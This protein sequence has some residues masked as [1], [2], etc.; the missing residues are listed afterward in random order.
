MRNILS[1]EETERIRVAIR[2]FAKVI[3]EFCQQEFEANRNISRLTSLY[4]INNNISLCFNIEPVLEMVLNESVKLFEAERAFIMLLNEDKTEMKIISSHGLEREI[5]E[6]NIKVGEGI[7]GKVALSGKSRLIR[8]K[9]NKSDNT[10][11]KSLM[12]VPLKAR[13]KVL[14]VVNISGNRK[15]KNFTEDDMNLL[16]T[17]ASNTAI[18]IENA[19]LY[20]KLEKKA[21]ELSTLFH[22]GNAINSSLD[23]DQVLQKVLDSAI[24]L[25][26]S[27]KGS[28]ML[29]GTQTDEMRIVAAHG[30]PPEIISNARVKLGEGISGKVALEGKPRLMKKGVRIEESKS[31]KELKEIKSAMSAPLTFKN[32]TQGVVNISDK[33]TDDNFNEEDMALLMMLANQAATAIE[34]A[35]LHTELQDLFISSI[36]ALANAIDARDPYTRGHSERVT[37]YSVA[38]SEKLGLDREE[39]ELIRYA[40]LLHDIGKINIPDHILNKP[41]KLTDEEFLLMKKHPVFGAQI[42]EPVKAFQKIL[43]YMFLHHERFSDKKGYP[44]GING[45]AIPIAARIIAV[46]DSFDAMTSDRP[47]RKSLSL[48]EAVKELRVNSGTQFDPQIVKVFLEAIKEGKFAHLPP[49]QDKE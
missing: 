12:Y 13:E 17:L 22:I 44:L 16:Q 25:L 23:R 14:G 7:A 43:P 9:V 26:D 21:W 2:S 6:K 37:D 28:L 49:F 36:K 29:I 24:M 47:Y 1:Q 10:E 30:L 3:Y 8:K 4:N 35:R 31:S 20:E 5:I 27:R 48:E 41:G 32:K 45:D 33:R 19:K 18:S 34:N 40:A 11:S 46:A 42:M 15:G 38:M 39:V